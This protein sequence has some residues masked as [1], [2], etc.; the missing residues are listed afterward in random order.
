MEI[1]GPAFVRVSDLPEGARI[2]GGAF[3]YLLVNGEFVSERYLQISD[4]YTDPIKLEVNEEGEAWI[5]EGEKL[6]YNS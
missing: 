4:Y 3:S 2:S 6:T 1:K 5:P